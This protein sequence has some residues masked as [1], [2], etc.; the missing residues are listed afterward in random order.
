[1]RMGQA[2][3]PLLT[4]NELNF[5][6]GPGVLPAPVLAA[7]QQAIV[8]LPEVGLSV[9]G[10]SHRSDWFATVVAET[11]ANVRQLLG[12]GDDFHVL[13]LQ[14]G[15]SQQFAMI[16]MLLLRGQPRPA[17]YLLTGYWSGK[18]IPE[19]AHEGTV[20]VLW[21]GQQEG[22]CRL[23]HD[24]EFTP[25]A[26]AAYFHYVSNETVEGLQ[27]N[28]VLGRDDVPRIC[29]M[30]S[31]FLSRPCQAERFDL[32]YAHAQKNL[33]PAGVTLVV[34]NKRLLEQAPDNL[35]NIFD[36]RSHVAMR[37]I[38]NTPPVFAIYVVMLVT[39]WLLHDIGGLANMA[40]LNQ[41]KA[42][43]LYGVIDESDSFYCSHAA[44]PDRSLMNVVFNLNDAALT[45]H[46]LSA[47]E[48]AGFSGLKGHR[49][50]GGLRAS[51]YN[52]MTLAAV[53]R[54]CDFMTEFRR[55]R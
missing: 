29:D 55:R 19:A 50:L 17:E 30:S 36:Y 9:L 13:L 39:R 38:Y 25:A 44:K 11:E 21:S 40:R 33:G 15:A 24:E 18:A 49:S 28:R 27:F 43:L 51:I 8:E 2:E 42:E 48:A 35:H 46:F 37:S 12:L 34:M 31:D 6:G 41:R 53:E 20:R 14:G 26:D 16:P 4:R 23:P 22:F 10:I 45:A 54:L 47:A 3:V 5:S 1:M 52:G 7:A 32:I